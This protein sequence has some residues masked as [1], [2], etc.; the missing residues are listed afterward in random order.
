MT[1]YDYIVVGAGSA[2]AVVAARLSES[3][4]NRVLLIEAGGSH[5][6]MNVQVPAA[7]SKQFKSKL[8]WAY[9]SEPEQYLGG[10]RIFMPRAKMLG[11]CSSMNAMIYI[12]GNKADYDTWAKDGATGWSYADVLPLFRKSE[13]NSR[14]ADDYHGD[15][16]PL[17]VQDLRS[18]N[19]MSLKLVEAMAASGLVRNDDFNGS[20]QLGTGLYQVTQR[21]GMRWTTA[22][23]YT[24]P[25]RKR[26]NLS[27]L[28]NTHVLRIRIQNGVAVGLEAERD[29]QAGFIRATKEVIVSAG[30]INT[31]QL[32]MLS[33]IGPADHLTE[34]DIAVIVDNPN[35]GD[36]YMDHPAYVMNRETTAKGTLHEAQ[37]PKWLLAYLTRR[38]GLLT[39]NVG[40]AGAFFHT[41]SGYAAPDMQYI[42]APGYFF[43]HGFRTYPTPAV[44]IGCS[45]VGAQSTGHIRLR[46]GD[47]KDK[48][49]ITANY[50]KEPED[51]QAMITAIE[52]AREIFASAPLRDLVGKE[53]HPG[54]DT[55]TRQA[56]DKIIRREVEH[57]YHPACTARIGTETTGV[58]DPQLRVHGV[59]GLRVADASVF[60]AI[61]HGNTNAPTVMTGEKAAIMITAMS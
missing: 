48:P 32:L 59:Q 12:R 45:L 61:P 49:A 31:P 52:Q 5:R 10:R 29:G 51:M 34:H 9:F 43:D 14:G 17:Y 39:S 16:G 13:N 44:A 3:A 23:G 18:P 6:H 30:A 38:T 21:R 7:F 40:E 55:S 41:R 1:S 22:D 24:N 53:I 57:T 25:A 37:S 4:D 19:D 26:S 50:L 56:L 54:G 46:S 36:H 33:G 2:G 20:D 11:G 60:P 42:C 27:V 58:V 47:P 28:T 35:V 15:S 8:D